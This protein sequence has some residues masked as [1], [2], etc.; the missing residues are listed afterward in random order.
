MASDVH[1]TA[2]V[3]AKAKIGK[4]CR[5]G[6]YCV[7][8]DNVTMGQNVHLHSHV[9]VTGHT[10]LGPD[11]TLYPF[12][13]IGGRTQD[14]KYSGGTS[15]V[16]VGGG[17]T[18]REYVTVHSSTEP[19]GKTVIGRNC[20]FLAYSHIAH[21]CV[22]GDGV[23]MSNGTNL[24]GHVTVESM[25][26][27]GGMCGIHQFVRIGSMAMVSAMAKVVQD[28]PP[29]CLADGNPAGTV[30]INRVGM[31]RRDFSAE[32]TRAVGQAYKTI[33]R[34]GLTLEKAVA[35]LNG[36]FPE[37]LE[38]ADIVKFVLSSERGIARPST[39]AGATC[40][41]KESS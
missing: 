19:G 5:I 11:C 20:N 33:F 27:F 2:I 6:P 41:E 34:S 40:S 4:N 7:V 8:A 38:I 25:A 22:I 12:A 17:T 32:Q 26:V 14:L 24:A 23:I 36:E 18:F 3:S 30:T 39:E 15:Y 37:S 13:C 29:Y 9:V 1:P 35:E 10:V 28:I 31:R 16:R 21:D